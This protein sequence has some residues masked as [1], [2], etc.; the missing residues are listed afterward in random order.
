MEGV[1][2]FGSNLNPRST[3]TQTPLT[4]C[5]NYW[6]HREESNS[7]SL[8]SSSSSLCPQLS[9]SK[10]TLYNL[11][12]H[13]QSNDY[14]LWKSK[15]RLH[16]KET[17][18]A[19]QLTNMEVSNSTINLHRPL[20]L[21]FSVPN[22]PKN[23]DNS[24]KNCAFV[25]NTSYS[26]YFYYVRSLSFFVFVRR[27]DEGLATFRQQLRMKHLKSPNLV[28]C[29]LGA[30]SHSSKINE[31]DRFE[32]LRRTLAQKNNKFHDS[33]DNRYFRHSSFNRLFTVFF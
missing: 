10:P 18:E 17:N 27:F 25:Q 26:K 29:S 11:N 4:R 12:R 14:H 19:Q 6:L 30:I 20:S 21:S 9:P 3:G 28:S 32:R 5:R 8:P 31:E 22:T 24:S 15:E 7:S 16:N 23:V 33:V 1:D 13:N 2:I